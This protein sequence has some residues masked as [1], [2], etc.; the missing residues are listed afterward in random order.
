MGR[1]LVERTLYA[2]ARLRTV[3]LQARAR[4]G[5][6]RRGSQNDLRVGHLRSLG[7]PA[8]RRWRTHR[9]RVRLQAGRRRGLREERGHDHL[10]SGGARSA[11]AST[12]TA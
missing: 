8:R 1:R 9:A 10:V 12:G 7:H 2:A 4:D 6:L 5:R 11:I 3:G